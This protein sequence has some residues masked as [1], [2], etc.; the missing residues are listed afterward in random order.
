MVPG[1]GVQLIEKVAGLLDALA[2]GSEL[3]AAEL[4]AVT[5]EPR[6]SVYR[7]LATLESLG[8]VEAGDRRGTVRLGL[9]LFQLGSMVA[10]RFDVRERALPAMKELQRQTD[11]TVML[12]IRRG[13]EAVCIERLAGR[14]VSL[15]IVDVGTVM[16]LH[17]G[18]APRALL[19]HAPAEVVD[20][21]LDGPLA[22]YNASTVTS[23]DAVRRYLAE[24][25][26]TGY[27]VSDEDVVPGVASLGAPVRDRHGEVVASI[28]IAGP[29]PT[30]LGDPDRPRQ[31]LATCAAISRS[32]GW[33]GAVTAPA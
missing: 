22:A 19:A 15:V 23:A 32:M 5:G 29:S 3:T 7:L 16:P 33:D 1:N 9:R 28:S 27:V 17:T 30:I 24:V 18:A 11:Q 12:M 2:D 10:R 21:A 14:F 13:R 31:L 4:A 6:S 8:Y 26:E 20:A 25:R